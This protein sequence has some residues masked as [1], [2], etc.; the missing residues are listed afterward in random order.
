MVLGRGRRPGGLLVFSG[1]NVVIG[2][3]SGIPG[4]N[5][6]LVYVTSGLRGILG[7]KEINCVLLAASVVCVGSGLLEIVGVTLAGFVVLSG[8]VLGVLGLDFRLGVV[9]IGVVCRGADVVA[10]ISG[11]VKISTF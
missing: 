5:A 3:V 1:A 8:F 4:T 2:L 11:L 6:G 10:C 7:F 9:G